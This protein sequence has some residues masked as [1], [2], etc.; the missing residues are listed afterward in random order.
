MALPPFDV[1]SFSID[2][3]E[4][5]SSAVSMTTL[6]PAA[7]H[8]C[9][10]AFCFSGSL[11]ALLI[12]Y[13]TPAA[14][15]AFAMSGASNW[16]HRTDDFVSGS[17]TQTWMLFVGFAVAADTRTVAIPAHSTRIAAPLRTS[18][19]T[20]IASLCGHCTARGPPWVTERANTTPLGE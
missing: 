6:A 11:R 15:S 4:P 10:C 19:F 12:E 16:T 9:A 20:L 13:V 3:A 2:A 17:R 5:L 8:A 14:F 18:F 1:K 7:R